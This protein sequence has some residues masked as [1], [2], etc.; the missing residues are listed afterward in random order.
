MKKIPSLFKRD[1]EGTRLV[2]D[3][4]VPGSEWVVNGQG[5]ATVKHDGTACMVRDGKLFKRYDRKMIKRSY[6]RRKQ[7]GFSPTLADYRSAPAGWEPCEPEPNH[8]TGHWPGWVPVGDEPESKWHR[9]ALQRYKYP[10]NG[11]Y[12]LVGPKINGN[13]YKLLFHDLWPHGF[14]EYPP[15]NEPPRDFAGLS[16]WFQENQVEGIVW[17]H[18]DGRMVKIKRRDFGLS[19][20][21]SEKEKTK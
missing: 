20:P 1:Y 9:E 8:H 10:T 14:E 7:P 13:P 2:Y 17:H 19:W 6:K 12:E 21:V 4:L 18:L 5:V 15:N 11:T 3:E 16:N